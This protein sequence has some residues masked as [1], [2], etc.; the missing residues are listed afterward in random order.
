MKNLFLCP[1][2]QAVLNPNIKIL[3]VVSHLKKRGMILISPQPGNYNYIW[4]NSV[5]AEAKEGDLLTFCC[6]VCGD[7]LISPTDKNFAHM[8]LAR[9]G[10]EIKRVEFCRIFGKCATF[11]VDGDNITSYGEDVAH[12]QDTNFFGV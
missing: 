10:Q 12:F 2:C 7:D 8:Q 3:L 9:P 6:P 4:D 5:L 11:V 1:H